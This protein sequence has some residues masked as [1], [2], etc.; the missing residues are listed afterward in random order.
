MQDGDLAP[1]QD[2]FLEPGYIYFSKTASAVRTV[3]GSCV[4]VCLW[5]TVLKY[6]GVSHFLYPSTRDHKKA[7]PQYGNVATVALLRIMEESGCHRDDL[8]AQILGGAHLEGTNGVSI[9]EKNVKVARAVLAQ[10]GIDIVSE[11]IGGTMGRKIIF[12]TG[13]GELAVLKV[14]KIRDSDWRK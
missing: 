9:G 12:D 1:R 13:R 3:V 5:D 14:Q 4:A 2:Y 8:T 10:R 7:T 11:D 6:G